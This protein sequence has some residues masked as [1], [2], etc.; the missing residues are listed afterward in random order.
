MDCFCLSFYSENL[1]R[2]LGTTVCRQKEMDTAFSNMKTKLC[3]SFYLIGSSKVSHFSN[4]RPSLGLLIWIFAP[5]MAKILIKIQ[6]LVWHR[7]TTPTD[8][9]TVFGR[10]WS[11]DLAKL[12][13]LAFLN[14]S[15]T[16]LTVRPFIF[17]NS[18]RLQI[19]AMVNLKKCFSTAWTYF[20]L[21]WGHAK[22]AEL[23]VSVCEKDFVP[24]GVAFAAGI[25][26]PPRKT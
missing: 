10:G 12:A 16:I 3:S 4:Q 2:E 17:Q 18:I 24:N 5:K 9:V 13:E 7:W 11:G 14:C 8:G 22:K 21:S 20:F 15:M 25:M 26:S 6:I 1:L 23:G 19:N